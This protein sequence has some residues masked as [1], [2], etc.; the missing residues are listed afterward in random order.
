MVGKGDYLIAFVKRPEDAKLRKKGKFMAI[1]DECNISSIGNTKEEA[2]TKLAGLLHSHI[3]DSLSND[4]NPFYTDIEREEEFGN[5]CI[6]KGRLPNKLEDIEIG[7]GMILA[8]Y[9]MSDD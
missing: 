8:S 4:I 1:S 3:E 7:H 5:Y 9:D 2:A 6:S